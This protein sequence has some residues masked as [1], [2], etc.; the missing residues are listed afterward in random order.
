MKWVFLARVLIFVLQ[1]YDDKVVQSRLVYEECFL[2]SY[3]V[4]YYLPM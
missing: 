1:V 2:S 3:D 4:S